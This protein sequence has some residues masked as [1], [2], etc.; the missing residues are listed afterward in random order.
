MLRVIGKNTSS[1]WNYVLSWLTPAEKWLLGDARKAFI[2]PNHLKKE[3]T[4]K[5]H[6]DPHGI[7]STRIGPNISGY[8]GNLTVMVPKSTKDLLD[9]LNQIDD[10]EFG[11]S[12]MNPLADM[13]GHASIVNTTLKEGAKQQ[14]DTLKP[15]TG[16]Y[17]GFLNI[18]R[19]M[20]PDIF[21][22]WA[23]NN[24][25]IVLLDEVKHLTRVISGKR[26]LGADLSESD[27]QHLSDIFKLVKQRITYPL[28]FTT[29]L[30]FR[31]GKKTQQDFAKTLIKKI[32]ENILEDLDKGNQNVLAAIIREEEDFKNGSLTDEQILNHPKVIGAAL[33]IVALDGVYSNLM[34]ILFQLM[35]NPNLITELRAELESAKGSDSSIS[36]ENLFKKETLP[37]LHRIYL[38]GLR[39]D[40]SVP[41]LAR[42]T[43]T[44]VHTDHIDIPANSTVLINL[45]EMHHDKKRWGEDADKFNPDR[46]KNSN[47][48]MG[49][50]PFTP[51][52]LG[53][54]QCPGAKVGEALIK[55]F[56]SEFV[57]N[58]ELKPVSN[59]AE[60]TVDTD[61]SLAPEWGPGYKVLISKRD[62]LAPTNSFTMK[63]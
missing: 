36:D 4:S 22:R 55:L 41:V 14:R 9:V 12:A 18:G 58:Y 31:Q 52:S 16:D 26:W 63:Q 51:F 45:D 60:L 56:I 24:E 43:K 1:A 17:R 54:R 23:E 62:L 35:K 34:D 30:E 47:T 46:F 61:S 20:F 19:T 53:A 44:G 7:A 48:K 28:S 38:E 33:V 8:H 21:K 42:Y 37:V 15:F 3:L 11:R 13:M 6:D 10:Q 59:Q 49:E 2:D 39:H 32:Q 40:S 25:G 29:Q 27:T 5:A 57:L 50:A